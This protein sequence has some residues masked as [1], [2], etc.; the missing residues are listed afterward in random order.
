MSCQ[1]DAN[2]A[3]GVFFFF[4]IK[5]GGSTQS[6]QWL[7]QRLSARYKETPDHRGLLR[8]LTGSLQMCVWGVRVCPVAHLNPYTLRCI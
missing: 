7:N 6:R 8:R 2:F 5:L 1:L 3:L 4:L